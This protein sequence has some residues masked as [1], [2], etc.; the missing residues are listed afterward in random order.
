MATTVRLFEVHY[1]VVKSNAAGSSRAFQYRRDP[2]VALVQA[3]EPQ[4]VAHV[5]S[6]HIALA[7]GES[8]EILGTK[9]IGPVFA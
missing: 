9:E 4:D 8:I 7:P 6:E 3:A 2:K 5:L 1:Q